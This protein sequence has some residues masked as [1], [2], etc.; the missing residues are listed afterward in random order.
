MYYNYIFSFSRFVFYKR[1]IGGCSDQRA[2]VGLLPGRIGTTYCT[3]CSTGDCRVTI[4]ARPILES[5]R[6]KE[7]E[8][9]LS[10]AGAVIH[11]R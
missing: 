10:S 4:V 8:W 9:G 5:T 7:T 11:L 3:E 1:L 2:L 6:A